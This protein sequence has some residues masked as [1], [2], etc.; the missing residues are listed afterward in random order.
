MP[1]KGIFSLVNSL[2]LCKLK[3]GI[4]VVNYNIFSDSESPETFLDV[5]KAPPERRLSAELKRVQSLKH[6][7]KPPL[8]TTQS[9]LITKSFDAESLQAIL[10][11]EGE[12]D[13]NSLVFD[14]L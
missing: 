13:G 1:L 11:G 12:P 7:R 3:F 10:G 6:P 2:Y 4:L 8:Q 5:Q 9:N 14:S